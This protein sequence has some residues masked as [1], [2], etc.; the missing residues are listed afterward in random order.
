MQNRKFISGAAI[1]LSC[2]AMMFAAES[3]KDMTKR[4][5]EASTVFSEIMAAHDKAIPEDLLDKAHCLVIVPGVKKGAFVVGAEF[6]K[7][8]L[9][10]REATSRGWSAPAAIRLEGG[11]FGFQIGGSE[12]DVVMLVMNDRGAE[13]LMQSQFTLGGE[14][15]IAAGPV[16]RDSTAQTDAKFTAEILSWSRSRGV[17]AGIALKGATL[18]QDLDDNQTLYGKKLETKEIAM[19]HVRPTPAGRQLIASVEAVSPHEHK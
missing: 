5:T 2:S 8:F 9:M 17:F 19:G 6:G 1:L 11:S 10:C 3:S 18:R 12:T 15:E 16:G 7:G 4:L 14:G 13:R